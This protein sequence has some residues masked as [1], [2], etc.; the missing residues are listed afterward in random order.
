MRWFST[1]GT[2]AAGFSAMTS[3]AAF[4]PVAAADEHKKD[5]KVDRIVAAAVEALAEGKGGDRTKLA[6]TYSDVHGLHGGR[7]VTL[8]GDGTVEVMTYGP[9]AKVR[10]TKTGKVGAEAVGRV[11]AA[12]SKIEGWRQAEPMRP[13]VPDE[14]LAHLEISYGG[15]RTSIREWLR[16]LKANDRIIKVR[17]L[18]TELAE[19]A[20]K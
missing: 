4:V 10:E 15:D 2:L 1:V 12:V 9:G 18:L 20:A 13:G 7:K 19:A 11:I 5:E 8:K 14:G 17:D 6:V 16:D 3:A